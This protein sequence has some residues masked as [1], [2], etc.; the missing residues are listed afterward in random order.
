MRLAKEISL[1]INLID[2]INANPKTSEELAKELNV[3]SADYIQKLAS[4]LTKADLCQAKRGLGY[5]RNRM[6]RASDIINCIQP[7][8][9]ASQRA[10]E[11]QSALNEVLDHTWI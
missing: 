9:H 11:V 8:C 4:R 2:R 6:V 1:A 7:Q 10:G 5:W 3:G